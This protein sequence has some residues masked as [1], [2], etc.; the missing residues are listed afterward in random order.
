MKINIKKSTDLTAALE[1]YIE[2]KLLPLAKFV[3]HFDEMGDAEIWLGISRTVPGMPGMATCAARSPSTERSCLSYRTSS[4]MAV[5]N[6][7]LQPT[8]AGAIMSRRG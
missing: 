2:E 8:A 1:D 4:L 6:I 5:P 3:K 7:R